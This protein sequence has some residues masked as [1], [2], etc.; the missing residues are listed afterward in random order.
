MLRRHFLAVILV[1]TSLAVSLC[2]CGDT[3]YDGSSAVPTPPPVPTGTP[4]L[5]YNADIL[6]QIPDQAP[7]AISP[8]NQSFVVAIAGAEYRS[9]PTSDTSKAL[10][11]LNVGEKLVCL[12]QNGSYLKIRRESGEEGWC[13]SWYMDLEDQELDAKRD[14][15]ILSSQMKSETFIP[16]NGRPAY[17]CIASALNCRAEPSPTSELLYRITAG[18]EVTLC[19]IDGDFYLVE[20]GNDRS[21]YCSVNWLS[22]SPEF[23]VCPGGKDLRV[24]IPTAQN[25]LLYADQNNPAGKKLYPAIPVL[26]EMAASKLLEASQRFWKDGY[27]IIVYDAYRPAAAQSELYDAVQD[28]RFIED[29]AKGLSLHQRGRAVDISL[30]DLK[31][32][33]PLEMPSVV[34][35]FTAQAMRTNQALW[36]K[37]A[38]T[39]VAYLTKIMQ[40]VGFDSSMSEWWHF[41]YTGDGGNLPSDLDLNSLQLMPVTAYEA[42]N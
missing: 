25:K 19:G 29:P 12:D 24:Y 18:D 10:G 37:T 42:P 22:S 39:N 7:R 26:E 14:E 41:E 5:S 36:T 34:H 9:E 1:S 32:G 17:Y 27:A 20:L 38:E 13:H 23:A 35:S 4:R 40:S 8:I 28:T 15:Q 33:E 31:T 6:P 30:F 3:V 11:S 2:G 21:C 16:L